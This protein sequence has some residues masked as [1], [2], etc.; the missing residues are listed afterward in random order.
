MKTE[1]SNGRVIST[2]VLARNSPTAKATLYLSL[3][4][5]IRWSQ[6]LHGPVRQPGYLPQWKARSF[7]S[8]PHDEFAFVVEH[9]YEEMRLPTSINAR[10]LRSCQERA[11]F[12]RLPR[13]L[14]SP[15][16]GIQ[17]CE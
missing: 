13:R 11:L 6:K 8:P 1:V 12:D 4:P 2:S 7:A 14:R 3:L 16:S 9:P 5:S 15:E 10:N 17:V